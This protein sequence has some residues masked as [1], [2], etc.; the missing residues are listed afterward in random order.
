MTLLLTLFI[1]VQAGVVTQL[2]EL[3]VANPVAEGVPMSAISMQ[4]EAKADTDL[5]VERQREG[6][7]LPHP[8]A[9]IKPSHEEGRRLFAEREAGHCVLCHQVSSLDVPFQGNLGPDLSNLGARLTPG[10]IRLRIVDASLLNPE[11]VMPPYHR[12][13]GLHQVGKAHQGRPV[14]E[15]A[16]IEQ[17]VAWLA[18][19]K[20][21]G[22]TKDE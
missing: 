7:A 8:L 5:L 4:E 2:N 11:T 16:E 15:A 6:D 22:A 1:L 3:A 18:S 20:T 14:L 13:S 9:D 21:P 19:L 12:V 10:Q 17:L